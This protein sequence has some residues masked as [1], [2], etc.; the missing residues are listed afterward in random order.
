MSFSLKYI[1]ISFIVR[2]TLSSI[3]FLYKLNGSI[4]NKSVF[5]PVYANIVLSC[6]PIISAS[7]FYE[8]RIPL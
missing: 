1:Q 5:P 2:I 4:A 8:I 3:F 6:L 7:F